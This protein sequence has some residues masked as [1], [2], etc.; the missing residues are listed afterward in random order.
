MAKGTS[1][2]IVVDVDPALKS[3]VYIALAAQGST[4]KDWFLKQA[5][6]LC[7]EQRQPLLLRLA[8][9][10]TQTYSTAEGEKP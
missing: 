8:E 6:Q 3:E 1:G 5:R 2:R 4:L 10:P 9:Q 7:D